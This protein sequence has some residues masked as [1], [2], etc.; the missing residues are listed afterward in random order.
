MVPFERFDMTDRE[1][2]HL[3]IV[4]SRLCWVTADG[5]AVPVVRGGDGPTEAPP[6]DPEAPAELEI[7]E[8]L[9][10]V[11]ARDDLVQ[12]RD[13]VRA[14]VRRIGTLGPAATEDDI[15]R[16]GQLAGTFKKIETEINRRDAESGERA[17]KLAEIVGQVGGDEPAAPADGQGAEGEQAPG[18][19]PVE[20]GETPAEVPAGGEAPAGEAAMP[21][22]ASAGPVRVPAVPR[23]PTLNPT[24]REIAGQAPAPQVPDRRPEV[25][26]YAAADVPGFGSAQRITDMDAL[27][28][29]THEKANSMGVTAGTCSTGQLAQ[30]A[31]HYDVVLDE[32]TSAE[33]VERALRGI[34]DPALA[35]G[36]MEALVAAGGWCAPSQIRYEFFNIAEGPTLWDVPRVGIQRGGLRWPDSMSLADFFA[37][38]GAPAS[39][40]PSNAT[41]PWEWTELDDLSAV[42]GS[43]TKLCLRPPCP[44]FTEARLRVFGVCVLAGNLTDDAY[45][46]LTRH[47]IANVLVAHERVMNRRHIAQAVAL[48]TSVTPTASTVDDTV[49]TLL[50][51]ADLYARHTRIKFG[52][53]RDAVMEYVLPE[54]ISG[55]A[56]SDM[57]KRNGYHPEQFRVGMN[58]LADW[59][60]ERRIRVQFPTDW[61]TLPGSA[62]PANTMGAAT[63]PTNWPTSALGLMYAPGTYFIG[64]GMQLRLGL[65]RDSVLNETNDHTAEWSEEA[66]LVGM[67]GHEAL[68]IT[69]AIEAGGETI[70]LNTSGTN[71]P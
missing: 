21:V 15:A 65:M 66:S 11:D 52:M 27:V 58:L 12:L 9:R 4:N 14:E 63:P 42:T 49:P 16:A 39:G 57:A 60:D 64:G 5:H 41:M 53:A 25:E 50:G 18:G 44:D 24:L 30:L 29:A 20:A 7:P 68:L 31:R 71:G 51:N 26:I 45:P 34:I 3:D 32:Q 56:A 46:E 40:I 47:F 37:L 23:R 59:F 70:V 28:R 61:Q 43:P 48:A 36:G 22:A 69:N 62:G 8:D 13:A 38:S 67:F 55:P 35:P 33:D 2:L 10:S 19:Q 54:W 17:D 6:A 1:R